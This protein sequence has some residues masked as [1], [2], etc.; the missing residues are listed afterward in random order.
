M[1]RVRKPC[2]AG[3]ATLRW[4]RA[5]PSVLQRQPTRG[6]LPL[7]SCSSAQRS[8]RRWRTAVWAPRRPKRSCAGCGRVDH[9]TA[10][11][12]GEDLCQRCYSAP[13]RAC[14][15]CGRER[16]IATRH[17]DGVADLCDSC[18]RTTIAECAICREERAVHTTWPLGP[19][20][21]VCYRRE[22]RHPEVCRSCMQRKALIGRTDRGGRVCGPCAG[23]TRD[24]ICA[25]CGAAGEQHFENTCVRCSVIRAAGDLLA[26]ATGA[27]SERLSGLPD[28]LVHRGRVDSTMRWLLKPTPRAL[29][30]AIGAEGSITHASV[31]ACPAGQARHYLRALLVDVGVL[32]VRDEQTERLE[33][34][35]DEYLTQLPPHLASVITPYAQWKV[36]RTVRRRASRHRTTIG[37]ADSARE[38]IRAAARL[39]HHLEQEGELLAPLTQDALDRWTRGNAARSGDI[40]PFISWLSS[41]GQHPGLRVEHRRLTKPSEI[42]EEDE[43]HALIRKFIAGSDDTVN[44]AT[45]VAALLVLL[46]GARTD[47][48]HRLTTVD[49]STAGGRTHLAL[50]T[51]PIEI[52]DPVAQLLAR[53]VAE[54]EHNPHA[55]R[56][57][58]EG[59]HLFPSPRRLHEPIHPTTLGR[60]MARAGVSP[61]IVR[62]Y[63]MLALTSDLPAAVVASQI[64]LTPQAASR[65]AQFSQCDSIEYIIARRV[66]LGDCPINGVWDPAVFISR[67]FF[68]TGP[69]R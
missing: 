28:A 68:R 32:P 29:L 51:E 33:T 5:L 2:P 16:R 34:W 4:R 43:H 53:L 56:R 55:L 66:T 14:G 15:Q 11:V 36:L 42:S 18:Y 9:V 46:Y 6:M 67:W 38:R 52:P 7:S 22:L 40:A 39:L 25:I 35:V 59:S 45:R 10:I 26:S 44:L 8:N 27:I 21:G 61:R 12:D 3:E 20:C 48:I 63:A 57:D 58:G 50:S 60:W 54:A 62:N 65:W 47:R 49:T 31:D 13:V 64:G 41:T 17:Q 23:S 24:Y 69:R 37:V 30:Q 1:L 19:V